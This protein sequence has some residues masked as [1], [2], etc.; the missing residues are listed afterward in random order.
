[1]E[2]GEFGDVIIDNSLNL[3]IKPMHEFDQFNLPQKIIYNY[4]KKQNEIK[5]VPFGNFPL[6]QF[7]EFPFAQPLL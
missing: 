6:A 4:D 2:E 5:I 7:G 3:V 1:M